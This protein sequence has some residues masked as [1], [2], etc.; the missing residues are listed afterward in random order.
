MYDHELCKTH[1]CLN[2]YAQI[3]VQQQSLLHRA[4]SPLSKASLSATTWSFDPG[5]RYI[6]SDIKPRASISLM[7]S[8]TTA[9]TSSDPLSTL[10]VKSTPNIPVG[11]KTKFR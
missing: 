4:N 9:G 5:T 3:L 11:D 1:L 2:M 10:V 7:H 6:P 8:V